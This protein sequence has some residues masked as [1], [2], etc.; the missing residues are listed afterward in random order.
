MGGDSAAAVEAVAWWC[1]YCCF[2]AVGDH[3][4][5]AAVAVAVAV[6]D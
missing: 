5:V 6:G 4:V 1:V 3:Y 2:S